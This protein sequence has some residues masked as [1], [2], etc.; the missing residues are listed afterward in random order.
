M[1]NKDKPFFD[2]QF[3][4]AVSLKQGAHIRWT[5]DRP[6]VNWEELVRCQVRANEPY[7]E[8]KCQYS[9][10]NSDV[11]LNACIVPS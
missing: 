8:A 1:S 7:S 4:R 9:D 6:R 3:R 11:L 5:C 2:E 10:R